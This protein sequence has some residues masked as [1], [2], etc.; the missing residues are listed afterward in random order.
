M[1]A[2]GTSIWKRWSGYRQRSLLATKMNDIKW[3]GERVMSRTF[4]RQVQRVV[5]RVAIL[6]RFLELGRPQEVLWNRHGEGL[7][8]LASNLI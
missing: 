5:I 2:A 6:N 8:L 3:L 1:R 4:E 7:G